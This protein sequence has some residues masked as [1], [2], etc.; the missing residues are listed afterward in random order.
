[1]GLGYEPQV[2]MPFWENSNFFYKIRRNQMAK[3]GFSLSMVMVLAAV[4][5]VA[6]VPAM[7]A[8]VNL[9]LALAVD[10]SGSIDANE[11]NL[12]KTGYVDAFN[13]LAPSFNSATP[14]F[15][16]A[17]ALIYWSGSGMQQTAVGWTLIDSAATCT[18]FA[19]AI[20]GTVR[21]YNA[22]T[23]VGEA[24]QYSTNSILG[25]SFEGN[26][27]IIDISSDGSNNEGIAP[28]GPR[29]IAIADGMQIN[30]LVI[31][32]PS[33]VAYYQNNVI[34]PIPP[35]FVNFVND[36]GDF[37]DAITAKIQREVTGVP[38]PGAVYLLGSGLMG[39]GALRFRRKLS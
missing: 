31:Q 14:P 8:P 37:S 15:P 34:G 24:V 13:A 17:A 9:E 20:N 25:N 22:N 29:D 23:A 36:F 38:I 1:M 12:Q 3:K 5:L 2:R 26:R 16:F 4:M 10:V 7:A 39:L 33:L 27:K 28:N 21:P 30:A 6:A 32:D 18:A 19:A 11:F 35:A